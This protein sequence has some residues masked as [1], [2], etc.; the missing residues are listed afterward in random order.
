MSDRSTLRPRLMHALDALRKQADRNLKSK[1]QAPA[2]VAL[3]LAEA[4]E[5]LELA[6]CP[7]ALAAFDAWLSGPWEDTKNDLELS[8]LRFAACEFLRGV[9]N[10]EAW[11]LYQDIYLA[12]YAD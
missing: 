1:A 7:F 2:A 4:F 10:T 6:E 11:R 8:E 3:D 9:T 12:S 5:L